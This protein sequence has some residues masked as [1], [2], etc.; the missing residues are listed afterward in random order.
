MI[1]P[2]PPS[3]MAMAGESLTPLEL[4]RLLAASPTLALQS[5]GSG[6]PVMVLPGLGASNTSTAPMRRYLLWL[7]YDVQ[8]WRLGQNRGD[9]AAMLPRVVEQLEEFHAD[10]GSRVNLV[11][12]SLGGV[13]A[14]EAARDNP[15]LVRQ[16]VTMGS[17]IVGGPKYTS[18]GRIYAQRGQDVD[19][20][21]ATVAARE[22]T[23]INVPVTSIYSRR[24]GIV[25]W[26]ASIDR[27]TR[28][29]E[30]IEVSATHFGLGFSPAVYKILAQKLAQH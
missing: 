2:R 14:R 6:Q 4:P 13:L 11:G 16:V 23:P 25:G 15:A 30:N 28:G 21:A 22:S 24:D 19:A 18:L 27:R 10:S 26:Q 1:E 8:G 3:I 17:P 12:W 20:I 5:R 9:V 29:A 7:G